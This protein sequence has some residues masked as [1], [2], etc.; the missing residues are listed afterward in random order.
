MFWDVLVFVSNLGVAR[1][2]SQRFCYT[3]F[4]MWGLILAICCT[5]CLN[6]KIK[7]GLYIYLFLSFVCNVC[8]FGSTERQN[9]SNV[10]KHNLWEATR[11][12]PRLETK[13][14]FSNNHS[15]WLNLIYSNIYQLHLIH[16][17]YKSI[18]IY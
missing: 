7:I 2:A 13:S 18:K 10:V 6:N 14:K 9:K 15:F 17:N 11:A 16:L 4:D 5:L 8:Q 1:V 3:H 12:T